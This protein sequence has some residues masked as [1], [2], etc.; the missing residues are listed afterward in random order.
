[1]TRSPLSRLIRAWLLTSVVDAI[2]SSVLVGV[3]YGST[4][5]RLWQGV[6]ATVLG[7]S[8]FEGGTRTVAIGLL[9]HVCV[10]FAWSAVFLALFERSAAVR[11]LVRSPHGVL[12]AAALYGPFIWLV[13]SF[14]VIPLLVHRP[15]SI[16][17]RWWIQLLGHV[18][19]VAVPIVYSISRGAGDAPARS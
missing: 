13:M 6:A 14:I 1:M 11:R 7:P 15:P 9:M 19:F 4:V 8:A 18:P 12:K 5:A 16:T 17:Y 10:A 3:F 2:F